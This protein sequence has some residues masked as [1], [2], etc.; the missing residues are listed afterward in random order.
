MKAAF[1]RSYGSARDVLTVG[2]I[3]TPSPGPGEV[4]VAVTASGV[5]PTDWKT[6]AGLTGRPLDEFQIPHLDGSGRIDAVG[7]GVTGLRPGQR[8][9]VFLATL[10]NRFGTAAEYSV[11]PAERVVPMADSVSDELG[12]SLGVPAM[13]AAHCLGGDPAALEGKTVLVAGGAGAVG[14]YAIELAKHAGAYVV[15]TVSNDGKAAL[16]AAAGADL[17]LNYRRDDVAQEIRASVGGVDRFVEVALDANIDLDVSVANQG[18]VISVYARLPEDP[19]IPA[20]VLMS[21]NCVISFELLYD[22]NRSELAAASAWTTAALS[23][24]ALTTLPITRFGLDQIGDAH[25][26]V[27]DSIVGKVIVVP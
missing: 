16:A 3:D 11:L 25:R 2:E 20:N 1:Y 15:T 19:R 26:A 6:R 22:F 18:A 9:W 4:R 5:N 21:K 24:G 17:V 23:D 27:E 7:E 8:V 14:H 10:R 12:A 13:T